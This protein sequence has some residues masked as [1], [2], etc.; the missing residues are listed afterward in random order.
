MDREKKL[1]YNT[2]SAFINQIITIIH[3]FVLPRFYLQYYG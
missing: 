3:G 1:K 2:V